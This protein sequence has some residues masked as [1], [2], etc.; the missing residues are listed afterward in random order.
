MKK[1]LFNISLILMPILTQAQFNRD[2]LNFTYDNYSPIGF[3]NI[4]DK[5][6]NTYS[7]NTG[8]KYGY[9]GNKF[10]IGVNE[11]FNSTLVKSAESNIKDEQNFSLLGEY[12]LTDKIKTGGFLNHIMYSDNRQM[13]INNA[14]NLVTTLYTKILPANKIT[15][16]PFGGFSSNKQVNVEDRGAIYG[17]EAIID[18]LNMSDFVIYSL[19]KYQNEDI[20]P[21]K[22]T[23]RLMKLNLL[24]QFE[25]GINNAIT[26]QYSQQRKDFYFDADSIVTNAFNVENN[27]QSR[28]E[29]T[30]F[31]QDRI[32][33]SSERT[34]LTLDFYGRVSWRDIDRETRYIVSDKAIAS[35]FDTKIEEFKLDLSSQAIY[36]TEKFEGFAR[37][38]IS[39]REEKHFPKK[40]NGAN[41][42][43]FQQRESSEEQ[44]NNKSQQI[45]ISANANYYWSRSDKIS[46]SLFHRKLQYD[47]PSEDNYDDRDEL[48]SIGRIFY[49]HRFNPFFN[50]FISLEGNVNHIVYIFAERSS[51]NNIKR[52]IKLSSGGL[53]TGARFVSSNTAEVSA[54]YTV[55]DYQDLN[56]NIKSF[57]FRQLSLKDSSMIFLSRNVNLEANGYI[58]LSEQ[59]D[60]NWT[61][62][63]GRPVRFLS[64][65]YTEPKLVY[66]YSDIHFGLGLRYFNLRTYS[67]DKNYKKV[68]DTDYMSIG[69]ISEI[70]F[71]I[72]N[73]LDIY[74][75][76]WYEFINNE[77]NTKRELANLLFRMNWNF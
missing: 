43:F 38:H 55:Y 73:R 66:I 56:P 44:K 1:T 62:F 9:T 39:E 49:S 57:A 36:K 61:D 16:T 15:L 21:R 70:R 11:I 24:N 3:T 48:L 8:I 46:M 68:I 75:Y 69:P 17:S 77:S 18:N 67:Y 42:I 30:Y 53:Y 37:A 13:D 51:N 52:V 40:I 22:N 34:G 64:E 20:S 14:S 27:I 50:F 59:G 25:E 19:L 60:F 12:S 45:T 6:L 35:T 47:T 29:S 54:N 71:N 2:S 65:I 7:L 41:D 74:I 28:T 32:F 63:S 5:Q 72:G 58:K 31:L 26:A 4:F 76:G 33:Y 10:F 23:V